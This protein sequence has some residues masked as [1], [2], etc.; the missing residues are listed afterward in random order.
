MNNRICQ[1]MKGINLKKL[2]KS[3]KIAGISLEKK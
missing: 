2:V 1:N 3:F